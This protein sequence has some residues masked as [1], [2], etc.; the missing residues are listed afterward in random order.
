[1]M[2]GT[3]LTL[4]SRTTAPGFGLR[5]PGATWLTGSLIAFPESVQSFAGSLVEVPGPVVA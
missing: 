5:A 1:M 4:G 3:V 2:G